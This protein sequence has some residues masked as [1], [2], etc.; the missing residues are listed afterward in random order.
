MS[1]I[2]P[3]YAAESR[4][5][6]SSALVKETA[7][8]LGFDLCG[9]CGVDSLERGDFFRDWL[10][11]GYAGTMGYLRR[12]TDSRI[13][14]AKWLPWARSVIV[15]GLNYKQEEPPRNCDKRYGRIAMY[16]WGEDYHLVIREKLERMVNDLHAN[17]IQEFQTQICVDTSAVIEREFAARAGIGWIGKNT[18]VLNQTIGSMFFLGLVVT[19]LDLAPDAQPAD[20]CGSCTRCLDACPTNAFPQPYVMDARR[21]ISYLTIEN[22]GDIDH[23]LGKKVGDWVF[24]CDVC[25]TVCPFN[26]K[27]PYAIDERFRARSERDAWIYL[28]EVPQWD[29]QA[30]QETVTGK[31]TDRATLEMWKRNAQLAAATEI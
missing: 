31:A 20:H 27:I 25:Q 16:A 7:K 13:D 10:A 22:R 15:T 2:E 12:H 19:N 24:G 9:I 23:E 5:P 14:I 17:S 18:L 26:S 3:Q 4:S 11:R 28:D 29:S 30:Y 6:I 21:C 8:R 1:K